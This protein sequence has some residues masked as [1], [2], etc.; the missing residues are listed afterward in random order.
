[1]RRFFSKH[2]ASTPPQQSPELAALARGYPKLAELL[3]DEPGRQQLRAVWNVIDNSTEPNGLIRRV[4]AGMSQDG[5]RYLEVHA[6]EAAGKFGVFIADTTQDGGNGM[7]LVNGVQ[8]QAGTR[9][10]D[11]SIDFDDPAATIP[12]KPARLHLR[13]LY[14]GTSSGFRDSTVGS[15]EGE[16]FPMAYM[17][18]LADFDTDNLRATMLDNGQPHE[19]GLQVNRAPIPPQ[20]S[21]YPDIDDIAV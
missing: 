21:Q 17:Q 11:F 12:G 20:A 15:Y 18:G 5:R 13:P 14:M 19:R 10:G 16:Y 3:G 1:M 6:R 8:H 7:V 2:E 9:N 4:F